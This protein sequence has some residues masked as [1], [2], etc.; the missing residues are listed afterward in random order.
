MGRSSS[1]GICCFFFWRVSL[2]FSLK[3]SARMTE[4]VSRDMM[5]FWSIL[6]V[7]RRGWC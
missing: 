3:L 7:M 2:V 4:V 1:A 5:V 6:G